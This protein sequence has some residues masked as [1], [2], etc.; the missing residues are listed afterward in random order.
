MKSSV[1]C[2]VEVHATNRCFHVVHQHDII[3]VP[4]I[5]SSRSSRISELK[6][7]Y[8]QSCECYREQP[9]NWA[10]DFPHYN[11]PDAS[12]EI[13][14]IS[15]AAAVP[16]SGSFFRNNIGISK[17]RNDVG[18]ANGFLSDKSKGQFPDGIEVQCS[19]ACPAKFVI[20]DQVGSC[21][22][23]LIVHPDLMCQCPTLSAKAHKKDEGFALPDVVYNTI[24]NLSSPSPEARISGYS[25]L[26]SSAA[27]GGDYNIH[28]G[29]VNQSCMRASESCTSQSNESAF[30]ED[31]SE[32]EA[33]MT[34]DDDD[35]E[36]E[37]EVSSGH[38][39][40]T[41]ASLAFDG[42]L[43]VDGAIPLSAKQSRTGFPE[44]PKQDHC[45]V[46]FA[47]TFEL[48]TGKISSAGKTMSGCTNLS[49][50]GSQKSEIGSQCSD[51]FDSSDVQSS[52]ATANNASI[53][54][55]SS[56]TKLRHQTS[57]SKKS[58][59]ENVKR[60]MNV[61]R[62][63]IPEGRNLDNADLLDL[64][65]RHLK[66]LHQRIRRLEMTRNR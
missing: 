30:E 18:I 2:S 16:F 23:R 42:A 20:F 22:A 56:A 6:S 9:S 59:K 38:S 40:N 39:P 60:A 8:E 12:K 10:G 63:I 49:V 48:M 4:S 54:R 51:T 31:T 37:E 5:A 43:A 15:L 46:P 32:L 7:A 34:S 17:E 35:Y 21:S 44:N 28:Q 53:S 64:A 62:S 50:S 33:L 14:G 65:V 41:A 66:S 47:N 11:N 36:D 52:D 45:V 29:A 55:V 19:D 57:F 13:T 3:G 24:S 27:N 25:A 58:R 26:I 1:N 61:L